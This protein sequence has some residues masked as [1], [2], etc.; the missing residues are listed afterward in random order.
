M[1]GQPDAICPTCG[2]IAL[3]RATTEEIELD[4]SDERAN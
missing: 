4:W 3:P 2:S 1:A